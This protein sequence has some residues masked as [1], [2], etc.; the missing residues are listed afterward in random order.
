LGKNHFPLRQAHPV[1]MLAR[2]LERLLAFLLIFRVPAVAKFFAVRV[3]L[4]Q[5][6]GCRPVLL[7]QRR[8]P[9]LATRVN[10]LFGNGKLFQPLRRGFRTNHR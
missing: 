9:F 5:R 6:I 4:Y 10:L 3:P 1:Q 2:R 7:R 8:D